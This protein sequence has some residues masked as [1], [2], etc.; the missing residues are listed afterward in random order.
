MDPAGAHRP[1][2]AASAAQRRSALTPLALLGLNPGDAWR[3]AANPLKGITPMMDFFAAHYGK[4]YAPNSRETVRRYTVHQF[5]DAGLAIAN[6]D[7]PE[8]PVNSPKAVY[9]I[10]AAALEL[11]RTYG[12]RQWKKG[13]RVYL[14]SW[15]RSRSVTA[16][17]L[18]SL[19]AKGDGKADMNCELRPGD[20]VLAFFS[21]RALF[22]LRWFSCEKGYSMRPHRGRAW[23]RPGRSGRSLSGYR[24]TLGALVSGSTR[25]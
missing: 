15:T 1:G 23:R 3:K 14:T 17:V 20:F 10:E 21:S 16:Q 18:L 12:G 7:Q 22:S 5:L 11:L 13:L 8:S 9:Q 6:P 2:P 25:K 4:K 19:Q 24:R